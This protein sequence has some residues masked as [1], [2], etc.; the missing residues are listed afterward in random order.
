MHVDPKKFF[1]I[2]NMK[3]TGKRTH[4]LK[5]SHG[6]CVV[7]AFDK[8][9]HEGSIFIGPRTVLS[10][11]STNR[12]LLTLYIMVHIFYDKYIKSED[13]K[14]YID[15]DGSYIFPKLNIRNIYN[16][17][18]NAIYS[19]QIY[20]LGRDYN[21]DITIRQVHSGRKLKSA[22]FVYLKGSPYRDAEGSSKLRSCLHDAMT[23]YAP[24]IGG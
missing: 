7:G 13:R 23:N 21:Q 1:N 18:Y 19:N 5:H 10:L 16:S 17:K 4:V 9:L 20:V 24:R 2:M 6:R 11:Y 15:Y 22:G 14:K 3:D 8:K 12:H